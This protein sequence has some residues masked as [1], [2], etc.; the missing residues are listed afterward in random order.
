M[1]KRNGIFSSSEQA[2]A[3]FA[4][5][6]PLA[7]C[8]ETANTFLARFWGL[9]FRRP[10]RSG[11][12]LL[13]F[14]SGSIHTFWMRGAIDVLWL[15]QEARVLRVEERIPPWRIRLAPPTTF[16]VL[17]LGSGTLEAFDGSLVG[18]T[19]AVDCQ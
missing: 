7:T 1:T 18:T 15:S 19:L 14:P 4:S 6:V 9:Q 11:H 12:G 2:R 17:E 16:A 5:G 10:L 13:L 8:V 3:I